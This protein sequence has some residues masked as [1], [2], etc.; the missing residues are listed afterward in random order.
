MS[1]IEL[2]RGYFVERY[3]A[4][5]FVP[6]AVLLYF[7]GTLTLGVTAPPWRSING[8][9]AAYALVLAFRIRDDLADRELDRTLHPRRITVAAGDLAPLTRIVY[10]ALG[11]AA[12]LVAASPARVA[13]LSVLA[14]L[15]LLL[16]AWY[17]LRESVRPSRFVNAAVV[18][19][20][21]PAIAFVAAAAGTSAPIARNSI[22]L[23]A[24]LTAIYIVAC[25]YERL[26]D[27]GVHT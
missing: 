21:Y 18:L 8:V 17:R 9:V 12:L 11:L 1:S 22:G 3:R 26:H 24:G 6:L 7:A 15:S 19:L 20:K 16:F 5:F 2:V 4:A 27:R 14:A 13:A 10:A 23:V 25:I